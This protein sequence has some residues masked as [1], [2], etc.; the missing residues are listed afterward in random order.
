MVRG[1]LSASYREADASLWLEGHEFVVRAGNDEA[2]VPACGS[3][4]GIVVFP[5]AVLLSEPAVPEAQSLRLAIEGAR[6]WF[7]ALGSWRELRA[8]L[9][10][11]WSFDL[12]P[13]RPDDPSHPGGPRHPSRQPAAA[14]HASAGVDT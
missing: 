3:W 14:E 11:S 6:V 2:R 4:P 10:S 9:G 12:A 8:S 1:E 13:A 7:T 5:A